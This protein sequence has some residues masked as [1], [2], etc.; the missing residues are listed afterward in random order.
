[1]VWNWVNCEV[2][3][4]EQ[5][6]TKKRVGTEVSIRS[7]KTEGRA[8][9]S[10]FLRHFVDL[11]VLGSRKRPPTSSPG[12]VGKHSVLNTFLVSSEEERDAYL[13]SGHL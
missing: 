10:I 1:M 4:L 13:S 6:I 3:K 7:I 12:N 5:S 9:L 11:H 8:V 2:A